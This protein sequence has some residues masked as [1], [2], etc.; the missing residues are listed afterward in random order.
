[1]SG[2]F[3]ID[4]PPKEYLAHVEHVGQYLNSV[5]VANGPELALRIAVKNVH[6]NCAYIFENFD[7]M[8]VV[9]LLQSILD[10]IA[11]QAAEEAE[12]KL[13]S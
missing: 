7:D 8:T 5:H 6:A 3:T 4:I 10:G 13:K 9:Q 1:M 11:R 12:G 2:G